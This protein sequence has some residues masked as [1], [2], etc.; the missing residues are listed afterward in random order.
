MP[1]AS[2]KQRR[3]MY[4]RHPEIAKRWSEEEK[5]GNPVAKRKR[6][7][8]GTVAC[9]KVRMAADEKRKEEERA[10]KQAYREYEASM[11]K[12]RVATAAAKKPPTPKT[13]AQIRSEAAAK[14]RESWM[15]SGLRKLWEALGGGK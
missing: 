6:M 10:K 8:P 4:A 7:E 13:P 2:E 12:R 5:Q 3:F 15:P 1:F 14:R 9:V 11:R